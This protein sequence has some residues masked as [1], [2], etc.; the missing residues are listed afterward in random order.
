MNSDITVSTVADQT[1]IAPGYKV[2]DVMKDGRRTVRFKSD[3]PILDFFSMQSA[4]YAEKHD[5]WRNVDLT[6]YY[7]PKHPME[8][9]RM[10]RAMKA[11][12]DIYNKEFSPYQFHQLRFLEFPTFDGSFG[13]P[14]SLR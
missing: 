4:A 8:V 1:P 13:L 5:K 12:M 2:S 10:I 11:S 7:D 3:A 14:I 9:D 6:V